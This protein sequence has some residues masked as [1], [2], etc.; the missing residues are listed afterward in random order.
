M[1]FSCCDYAGLIFFSPF[2]FAN[3]STSGVN[4]LLPFANPV[5]PA[6]TSFDLLVSGLKS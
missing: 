6:R 5:L 4:S 2:F 3:N 1:L